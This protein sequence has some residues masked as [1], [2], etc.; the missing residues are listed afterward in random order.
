MAVAVEKQSRKKYGRGVR[1][2]KNQGRATVQLKGGG[3][4]SRRGNCLRVSRLCAAGE[5]SFLERWKK[6]G[7]AC[8]GGGRPR[9]CVLQPSSVIGPVFNYQT[10]A[11]AAS[12]GPSVGQETR[13][14]LVRVCGCVFV[15]ACV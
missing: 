13:V 1:P 3:Q 15:R 4:Q 5:I 7:E 9:E 12:S 6:N 8:V 11:A 10:G 14:R 2:T